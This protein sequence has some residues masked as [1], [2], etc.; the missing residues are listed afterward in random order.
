[1]TRMAVWPLPM[2]RN[3][4]PGARRLIEAIEW[5]VTGAVRVPGIATPVPI[6]IVRVF[7]AASASVA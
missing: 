7:A 1:M 5:A 4:R 3:T 6:W 2:P